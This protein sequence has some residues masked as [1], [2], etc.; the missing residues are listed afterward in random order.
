MARMRFTLGTRYVL[1]GQVYIVRQVLVDNRL[2]VENQSFGGQFTVTQEELCAAW[3]CDELRFEVYGP[4]TQRRSESSLATSYTFADFQHLSVKLR[5]EA[6]RRYQFIR[7]LLLLPPAERTR[8]AI[9]AHAAALRAEIPRPDGS[10]PGK[11][12]SAVGEA[13]SRTSLERWMTAFV[14]SGY[15]IRSLVPATGQQGGKGKRRLNDRL[16]QLIAGV[17][18]ECTAAPMYRTTQEVYLMIVNRVAEENRCLPEEGQLALPGAATVYRRIRAEGAASLLRRRAS[19]KEA[20]AENAVFPGPSPT[21]ILERVEIDH[22][23]LDLFLVDEEDRLPIGRPTLT[24]ALDVYSGF[25]FGLYVGFEPPSYR[26]VQHCLLYGILPKADARTLFGTQHPWSAFGLPET[27]VIDNAKEFIGRDLDD[28]CGQL[29]IILERMPVRT[30]WFKGSVERFFR[31]N[32]TG[33]IHTLPGTTFSNVLERGDYDVFQHAC[34]SLSAFWKILHIF[35]LDIYAQRWHEGV[36]GIPAKVWEENL[37]AGFIPCLHNT[38]EEVRILLYRSEER[39]VQRS[40]ID[41]ESLRYQSPALARLRSTLPE[42]TRVRIKYDP[43]DLSA[44][45]MFDPTGGGAWLRVPAV[46]MAYTQGLS[47]WKHRV[48]RSYVLRQKQEVDIYA[49]AAAKQHIQEI[50]TREFAQTRKS[51]GRKTAARFLDIGTASPQSPAAAIITPA[52]LRTVDEA[53]AALKGAAKPER[54]ATETG[55]GNPVAA[56][57]EGSASESNRPPHSTSRPR[58]RPRREAT[59]PSSPTPHSEPDVFDIQGWGGDYNLPQHASQHS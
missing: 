57:S 10:K 47:L 5:N 40:G 30:P 11:K 21:R 35:L 58:G 13:I 18:A 14:S 20:Q 3:A 44:L 17:L 39:T 56:Q 38:V 50:V 15:D 22:T 46:D 42:G 6:W 37:Q 28:A 59:V 34:I 9:A 53:P 41:F 12:R 49:L 43:A 2:L 26:T 16:E 19:R 54:G 32:N 24:Y 8:Q 29:G 1:Q 55:A 52:A 7:P 31:T 33:L 27:L 51:R 4:N 23:T 36:G 25:P 45:Y 48:I